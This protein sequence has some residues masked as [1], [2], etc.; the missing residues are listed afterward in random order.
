MTQLHIVDFK[1]DGK[2]TAEKE[3]LC[4]YFAQDPFNR[5]YQICF[6]RDENGDCKHVE[7]SEKDKAIDKVG[8]LNGA[9][10]WREL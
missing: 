9:D 6:Y 1:K 5:R 7:P 2:C 4:L 8:K 3:H 10:G